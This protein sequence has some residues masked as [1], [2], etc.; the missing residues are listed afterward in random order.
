M[1]GQRFLAAISLREDLSAPVA[2]ASQKPAQSALATIA[3][4][5]KYM[6]LLSALATCTENPRAMIAKKVRATRRMFLLP[7]QLPPVAKE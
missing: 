3:E 1:K 7:M 6:P 2:R 5:H 4:G